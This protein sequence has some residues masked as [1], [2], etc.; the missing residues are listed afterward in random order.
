MKFKKIKVT[1]LWCAGLCSLVNIPHYMASHSRRQFSLQA[2]VCT[3]PIIMHGLQNSEY[4]HIPSLSCVKFVILSGKYKCFIFI[5]TL[6]LFVHSSICY[7]YS[8]W[9]R[10][11]GIKTQ[12]QC[13]ITNNFTRLT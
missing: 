2:T 3:Y 1:V 8:T 12:K 9:T 11:S 7:K 13:S 10:Q 5:C 4:V 6:Y